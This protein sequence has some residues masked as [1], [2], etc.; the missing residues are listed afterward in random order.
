[1]PPT[2]RIKGSNEDAWDAHLLEEYQLS[3]ML[4]ELYHPEAIQLMG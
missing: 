1:V 2:H 3:S 4:D